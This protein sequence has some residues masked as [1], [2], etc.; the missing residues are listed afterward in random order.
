MPGEPAAEPA[1]FHLGHVPDQA[2]QGHRGGFHGPAGQLPGVEPV[3][4]QLQRQPLAVQKIGQRR[5]L[6]SQPR[7][8]CR[9]PDDDAHHRRMLIGLHGPDE[10][11]RQQRRPTIARTTA[12]CS[13]RAS[14]DG[15]P[16]A[17]A[18]T[19]TATP[20]AA[21]A[22]TSASGASRSTATYM[23]QPAVSAAN[24]ASQRRSPSRN[25]ADQ[26]GRR[27]DGGGSAAASCSSE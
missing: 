24:A 20:D 9:Q 2:E 4:L 23:S 10:R 19:R 22:C 27:G 3:A 1:A 26:N 16:R 21:T 18:N 5:L 15:C 12:S 11:E 6:V 7:A 17:V 8:A 13:R 25:F 14:R